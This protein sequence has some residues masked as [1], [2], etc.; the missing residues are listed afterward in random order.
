MDHSFFVKIVPVKQ[1]LNILFSQT[2]LAEN[3]PHKG[4]AY[5]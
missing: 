4:S 2:K 5:P 1:T 3:R